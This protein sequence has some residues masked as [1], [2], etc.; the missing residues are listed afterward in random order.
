MEGEQMKKLM[1]NEDSVAPTYSEMEKKVILD[2]FVYL[3][4]TYSKEERRSHF[5]TSRATKMVFL[6]D[7]FYSRFN[8]DNWRQATA[9]KWYY[10]QYGPYVDLTSVAKEKFKITPDSQKNLFSLRT[11]MKGDIFNDLDEDIKKMCKKV[12]AKT[13]SLSYLGFISYVYN[14]PAVKLSE[15][16]TVIQVS[17]IAEKIYKNQLRFDWNVFPHK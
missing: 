4:V 7:W 5:T 1:N 11:D 16:Y 3:W 2:I 14:T 9:I 12:V 15:K 8:M 6:V 17:A 13:Q 10:H